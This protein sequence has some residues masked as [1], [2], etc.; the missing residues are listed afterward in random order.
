M[1]YDRKA[2]LN[3][4]R[5]AQNKRSGDLFEK[6]V[7]EACAVYRSAGI[8]LIEKTP[9]PFR[10]TKRLSDGRFEGHFA[11]Q[12]QPD[13]KGTLRDGQS[14]V[15]DAK[16]TDGDK[17]ALSRLS[18]TQRDDLLCHDSFGAAAGV[19]MGFGTFHTIFAWIPIKI[20]LDAK[21]ENGHL[22]WSVEDVKPWEVYYSHGIVDFLQKAEAAKKSERGKICTTK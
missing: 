1:T 10:V 17:I 3:A 9:E 6:L 7:E 4:M 18:D 20:F 12:A 21:K 22:Y 5:G 14:I 13:F 19:L 11:A 15:F 2:A 16:H 8:A